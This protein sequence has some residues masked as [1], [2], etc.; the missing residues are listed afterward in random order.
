ME[1]IQLSEHFNYRKLLRF[2]LPSIVMMVFTSIYSVVDGIFVSNF[3]GKT[4]FAAINLIMPFLQML[5]IVG[6]MLGTG[7]SAL[8]AKTLGEGNREKANSTFSMLVYMLIATSVVLLILG[9]LYIREVAIWLGAEG[10]M[11]EHCVQYA[12]VLL[13]ALPAFVLQYAFQSFWVTADKPAMGLKVSIGA[14]IANIILDYV[15]IV[16]FDWGLDGAAYA[17][18][19]SQCIGGIVPIIYFARPNDSLLKLSRFHYDGKALLKAC[20]NGSSEMVTNLSMSIVCMLYNFQLMKYIGEN[21]VAAYGVIMYTYFIPLSIF[22]G[23]SIGS[24]PIVSYHY[25]AQ[26]KDELKS[27]FRKSLALLSIMGVVT[28]VVAVSLSAPLSKIFVGYDAQLYELTRHAFILYSL[29]YLLAGI[30]IYASAFFTALNDG[31]VSAGIS[32]SRT[33]VFECGAVMI[34]PFLIGIDGIWLSILCAETLALIVS[35]TMFIC[36]RKRYGY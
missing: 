18:L 31:L 9:K 19:I 36:Y 33:L 22:L 24:A 8:V 25:G 15:F 13:L 27:L 23:Y 2:T 30:N 11:I 14:G 6:L 7:G 28:T 1:E 20:T 12:N 17:T 21:G 5:G 32:F 26:N 3:V 10:D 34:L 29:A 35:I 16:P 4:P